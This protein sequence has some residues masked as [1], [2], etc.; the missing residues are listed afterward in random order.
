MQRSISR[1]A[2][3]TLVELLVTV[4]IVAIIMAVSY[5]SYQAQV[6]SGRRSD[7]KAELMRIAQ[8]MERIYTEHGCY[9]PGTTGVCG[10]GSPLTMPTGVDGYQFSFAA[11]SLTNDSFTL[12]ATPI[13]GGVQDGDGF[14]QIDHLGQRAWDENDADGIE[15]EHGENDWERG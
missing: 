10:A 6:Q 15:I 8:Y 11:G 4:A 5:P 3:V 2:G 9:D 14:L 13:D 7:A 12:L 1:S